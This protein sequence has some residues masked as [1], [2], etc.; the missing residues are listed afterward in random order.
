MDLINNQQPTTNIEVASIKID[1]KKKRENRAKAVPKKNAGKKPRRSKPGKVALRQMK[2]LQN[3][4]EL[5]TQRAPIVRIIREILGELPSGDEVTRLSQ[6]AVNILHEAAED[7]TVELFNESIG[8]TVHRT[9]QELQLKDFKKG[10]KIV[11]GRMALVQ[12]K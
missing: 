6:Q 11:H 9:A 8:L 4:V 2:K 3:T 1:E 10:V 12:H 7:Y 5:V